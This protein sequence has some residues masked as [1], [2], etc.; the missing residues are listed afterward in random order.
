[1]QGRRTFLVKLM[2]SLQLTLVFASLQQQLIV[3]RQTLLTPVIKSTNM[4][5]TL[6]KEIVRVQRST[7]YLSVAVLALASP[8]SMLGGCRICSQVRSGQTSHAAPKAS[9]KGTPGSEVQSSRTQKKQ[10]SRWWWWVEEGKVGG[11]TIFYEQYLHFLHTGN[12]QGAPI[13]SVSV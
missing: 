13:Y 5:P 12:F 1:M 10:W 4:A 9:R 7:I 11:I 3:P 8:S 6:H 2:F